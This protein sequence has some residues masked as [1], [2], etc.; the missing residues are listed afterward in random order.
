MLFDINRYI[1]ENDHAAALMRLLVANFESPDTRP[2]MVR[3]VHVTYQAAL[4]SILD[5]DAH[6]HAHS[7]CGDAYP[8]CF[9][10]Q[11]ILHRM[12]FSNSNLCD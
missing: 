4:L 8:A 5:S 12:P 1:G 7:Y 10:L 9:G 3:H 11:I 6:A 2:I